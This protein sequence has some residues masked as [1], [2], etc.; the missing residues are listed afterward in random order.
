M[1]LKF[2]QQ[3]TPLGDWWH[4]KLGQ[5]SE[6]LEMPTPIE[7]QKPPA[8]SQQTQQWRLP[9]NHKSLL[10]SRRFFCQLR[11]VKFLYFFF[12]FTHG[13]LLFTFL[14]SHSSLK[15]R[16]RTNM[17]TCNQIMRCLYHV[18][19]L[20]FKVKSKMNNYEYCMVNILSWS[21]NEVLL[22]LF[23]S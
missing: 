4:V 22:A 15:S 3:F 23:Y 10:N 12:T 21:L 18:V 17:S 8:E 5:H 1:C 2:S 7:K 14:H 19:N 16:Q 6:K 20:L 9:K 13:L 11:H